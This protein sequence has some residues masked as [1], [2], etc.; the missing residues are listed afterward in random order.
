MS[1]RTTSYA[2]ELPTRFKKDIMKAA[3]REHPDRVVLSGMQRVLANIG[4]QHRLTPTEM[5]VIFEELGQD[6][7]IPIQRMS[8]I[9]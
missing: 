1:T 9:L 2:Q 7:A 4:A 8:Q 3:A 5:K 6:G